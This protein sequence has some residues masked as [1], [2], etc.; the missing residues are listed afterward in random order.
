MFRT[1]HGA[2]KEQRIA[3]RY[4]PQGAECVFNDELGAA[5]IYSFDRNGGEKCAALCYAGTAGK[6]SSHYSY[7]NREQA[8]QAVA[9]FRQGLEGHQ[10][11][12][13]ERSA[14]RKAWVN[15]LQVGN[16]LHTCWGYDQTNV[17]FFVVTKVS[18]KM[19][20]V[21]K[22]TADYE[23]TGHMSGKTWPAMPIQIVG[24]ATKH[25]AQ[26]YGSSVYLNI[27]GHHASLEDGRE[28]HTSSYA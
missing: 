25:L 8:R 6:S 12:K 18:G 15:P 4:I 14:A 21:A 10:T 23:A 22:I 19:V 27:D 16:I 7:R 5:Y 2:S 3:A 1:L 17:D 11:R 13:A 28:H 9:Q 20:W 24:E 26:G